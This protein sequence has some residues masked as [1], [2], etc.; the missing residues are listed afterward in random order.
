MIE[1]GLTIANADTN[2]EEEAVLVEEKFDAEE[3][4]D[5]PELEIP[6]S[7][8]K[9][10]THPYD[11]VIRSLKDQIDDGTLI[12]ADK[13]QRRQVWDRTKSS[14]LI[15]SLLLNVPIPVC[16][17]A[18]LEDGT[19]SVID[20]QQRLTAIY[21]FLHDEY[22]LR[23]LKVLSELNRQKFYQLDAPYKRLLL[24]RTIRCIVILK[25][26][27]PDIKYDV[28]E[29]LNSGFVPLNA[30]ELR[31]SV[32]RGKLNDLIHQLSEDEV[33]QKA[34]RVSDIDKRMHDCEMILRFF[35]FHFHLSEYKGTLARFL[36]RYLESGINF[37]EETLEQHRALFRQTIDDVYYVFEDR[38][39]RRYTLENGWEKSLNRAIYDV[40]MLFFARLNSEDIRAMKDEIVEALKQ[41]CQDPEFCEAITSSTKNKDRIQMRLDKWR[42]ALLNIGLDVPYLQVGQ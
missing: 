35:A 26:S 10:V 38:A 41:V 23:A 40:V 4:E 31:N 20:G 11:F 42:E 37:D 16:Y 28:F 12:L 33:F 6:L 32:Y 21:R 2:S 5:S 39:F 34:R 30:Q 7:D 3:D 17:F 29:R 9:L 18:E 13:F 27:H 25:E 19:Y 1:T 8:R 22:P 36:D 24:S 15:E 14:R